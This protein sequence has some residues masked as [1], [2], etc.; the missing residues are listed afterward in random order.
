MGKISPVDLQKE[1]YGVWYKKNQDNYEVEADPATQ[2]LPLLQDV[3]VKIIMGTWCH[4]SQRQVPRFYK[5][6]DS[7]KADLTQIH[8]IAVDMEFSAVGHD[9]SALGIT[10]TPTFIFYRG[11]QE[12]NRIVE[13][14]VESLEKDMLAILRGQ[15][16][17]H[18]K[19]TMR[20]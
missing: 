2:L 7:I 4:D 5:I 10:N 15:G 11:G 3:K 6:L 20:E 1:T 16:Y 14:P 12:I 8:M 9:I 13:V 18:S 19:M 17:R